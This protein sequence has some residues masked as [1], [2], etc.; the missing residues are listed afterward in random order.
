MKPGKMG[1]GDEAVATKMLKAF[2]S[3]AHEKPL[4]V[5]EIRIVVFDHHLL[6]VFKTLLGGDDFTDQSSSKC[7]WVILQCKSFVLPFQ[8]DCFANF[9]Y[10]FTFIECID[11]FFIF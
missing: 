2:R 1:L 6:P 8:I 9:A 10:F 4:C 5:N 11:V 3:F 7:R